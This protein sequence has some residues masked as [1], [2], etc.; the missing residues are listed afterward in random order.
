MYQLKK[1]IRFFFVI[2]IF[3]TFNSSM[4]R[5]KGSF[6]KTLQANESL[7]ERRTKLQMPDIM[8]WHR[9]STSIV[10]SEDQDLYMNLHKIKIILNPSGNFE[11]A[12]RILP[13]FFKEN[14]EEFNDKTYQQSRI[15]SLSIERIGDC[16]IEVFITP[17]PGYILDFEKESDD[18]IILRTYPQNFSDSLKIHTTT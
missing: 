2:T 13:L 17:R 1:I 3:F 14:F 5:K 11:E 7:G 6:F 10:D 12:M 16:C 4:S 9:K 18:Q 8:E 15:G